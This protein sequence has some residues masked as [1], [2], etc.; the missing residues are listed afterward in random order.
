MLTFRD[1]FE[2]QEIESVLHQVELNRKH[3]QERFGLG[4][5]VVSSH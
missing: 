2:E 4:M 5:A 1:G 3:Q